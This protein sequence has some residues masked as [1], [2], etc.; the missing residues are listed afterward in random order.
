MAVDFDLSDVDDF[1][2]EGYSEL[3]ET[4]VAIGKEAID[5]A[6]QAG[7]YQNHTGTLRKGNEFQI[8]EGLVLKNETSYASF[9]EAKGFDVLSGA[10]LYAEKRLREEVE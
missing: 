4:Q 10:V 9:V 5:Y 8:D 1:F 7:D 2:D 3:M 6:H